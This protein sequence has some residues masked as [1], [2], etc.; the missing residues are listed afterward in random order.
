[1]VKSGIGLMCFYPKMNFYSVS[2]FGEYWHGVGDGRRTSLVDL[3]PKRKGWKK[4]SPVLDGCPISTK[5]VTRGR[6]CLSMYKQSIHGS[7]VA[8]PSS[9]PPLGESLGNR[10][11]G[12]IQ[13][14]VCCHL[15]Q[16]CSPLWAFHCSSY[17]MTV[18][19]ER[20]SLEGLFQ[21]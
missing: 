7:I 9:L 8:S 3:S 18:L 1:M 20:N 15:K 14:Q 11:S 10:V 6:Q 17:K 19:S 16:T 5:R 21:P 13:T 2:Y 12:Q 4:V